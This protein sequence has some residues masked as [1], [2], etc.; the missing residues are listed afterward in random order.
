M[1]FFRKRWMGAVLSALA[2]DA[3]ASSHGMRLGAINRP[4]QLAGEWIDVRH[5][6]PGDTSLWVLRVDGYDGAA[7]VVGTSRSERRYGS[8]YFDGDLRAGS[9]R[10]ICFA[11]RL[12]R[13]GATCLPFDL[14]TI[15][16]DGAS[17]RRLTVRGYRGQHFTGDRQLIER[18]RVTARSP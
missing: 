5:T 14:D 10:A 13:D 2:I 12:G 4:P 18:E 11:K 9:D 1:K 17:H 7:H 15:M 16:A 3:C 6:T 8:W